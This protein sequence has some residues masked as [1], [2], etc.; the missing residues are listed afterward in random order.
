MYNLIYSTYQN[1][2]LK[3][4]SDVELELFEYIINS[5]PEVMLA[6]KDKDNKLELNHGYIVL[7]VLLT[8]T[9]G[10][11]RELILNTAH[12]K[13]LQRLYE[14]ADTNSGSQK[15]LKDASFK[16]LQ[17]LAGDIWPDISELFTSEKEARSVL[18]D[19]INLVEAM[20][21]IIRK[22]GSLDSLMTIL[23]SYI[24]YNGLAAI[25]GAPMTAVMQ[26]NN[27]NDLY[28][29]RQL[30][31]LLLHAKPAGYKIGVST[32]EYPFYE[33]A[34]PAL[35][36]D[37][38]NP[39][40]PWIS[41]MSNGI[42]PYFGSP[43]QT[44]EI[45]NVSVGTSRQYMTVTFKNKHF[46]PLKATISAEGT[47]QTGNEIYKVSLPSVEQVI[48]DRAPSL[49]PQYVTGSVYNSFPVD[50]PITKVTVTIEP[51]NSGIPSDNRSAE[52]TFDTESLSIVLAPVSSSIVQPTISNIKL[53]EKLFIASIDITNND[54]VALS[55]TL[56]VKESNSYKVEFFNLL[57]GE[58]RKL[59]IIHPDLYLRKELVLKATRN[60]GVGQA[61]TRS[62]NVASYVPAD[63]SILPRLKTPTP[64]ISTSLVTDTNGNKMLRIIAKNTD[65]VFPV[66]C[67]GTMKGYITWPYTVPWSYEY[68]ATI[69]AG[70][71]HILYEVPQSNHGATVD[72]DVTTECAVYAGT[73]EE[74][75]KEPVIRYYTTGF[76]ATPALPTAPQENAYLTFQSNS[77]FTL[78]VANHTKN[79]NGI[80]YYSTDLET[81]GIWNG[82]TPL[83]SSINNNKLYLRGK[84]NTRITG[85]N[86]NHRLV[87]T[88]SN[89]KCIGNIE[90]LLDWETVASGNHPSMAAYCYANLFRDCAALVSAPDLPATTLARYCYYRMFLRCTSLASP[91]ALPATT[92]ADSCYDGMFYGCTA[93]VSA[94]ALPATTL[95]DSC[96]NGMFTGCTALTSA[97]ALL[98][99]TTLVDHCYG[100]MFQGCTGLTA[101]PELPA[102]TLASFCYSYMFYGC[103]SLTIA[104]SLPATTLAK[105]CYF[106]MFSGC[107]ALTLPPALPATTLADRCYDSMFYGCKALT[108]VPALP[109]TALADY[110]YDGMFQ[111][112]TSLTS[113]PALPATTLADYCYREMF[114]GC[115]S[116]KI[117]SNQTETCQYAWRIP[118]RGTGTTAT[119]WNVDMFLGTGG[120]YTGNPDINTTYYVEHPPVE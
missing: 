50:L 74:P 78:E 76:V 104:P 117:S 54:P 106:S 86:L 56:A 109:A 81:W 34:S 62:I 16:L 103:T 65:P 36:T 25:E 69:P 37:S 57:P 58:T 83:S 64:V 120:T 12:A 112:C 94:P 75:I 97:P 79:W 102:T 1:T 13:D 40:M 119:D 66:R 14:L 80:L 113:V 49:T 87:L 108:S 22:R 19:K 73:P 47:Y 52:A 38:E 7:L 89:I 28:G 72:F 11:S 21:P 100:S 51:H 35:I 59:T 61:L 67:Y 91:P 84:G 92:L 53:D 46:E 71:T 33:T 82:A 48:S 26:L 5:T 99:A 8:K 118:T 41:D 20:V 42:Y 101:A 4:F 27:K 17:L 18:Y 60:N 115:T 107:T 29:N 24:P 68:S 93:L 9:L 116:L 95:A 45:T 70:G 2:L 88:G 105:Y 77:P 32:R 23:N 90:N 96:Y 31:K 111:S 44:P 114:R 98:P 110:C 63:L 15:H 43:L 55:G 30:Y 39:I 6:Y 10:P 3:G 85:D